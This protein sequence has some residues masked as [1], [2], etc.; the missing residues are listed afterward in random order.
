MRPTEIASQAIASA[1]HRNFF[2]TLTSEERVVEVLT[3]HVG[4]WSRK[5]VKDAK[6]GNRGSLRT[7]SIAIHNRID[8]PDDLYPEIFQICCVFADF[9][10]IKDLLSR[11]VTRRRSL[12]KLH[13][14]I[15]R[16]VTSL[17]IMGSEVIRFA[18][19]RNEDAF[20][21]LLREHWA[22]VVLTIMHVF[23]FCKSSKSKVAADMPEARLD[24]L[25]ILCDAMSSLFVNKSICDL[26]DQ[27]TARLLLEFAW[28][29]WL[30][31]GP[32][33]IKAGSQNAFNTSAAGCLTRVTEK[34]DKELAF[35]AASR[36]SRMYGGIP[37][38][39]NIALNAFH[40]G[41]SDGILH[42]QQQDI[43][44]FI[45]A[46]TQERRTNVF[47][48]A[49]CDSNGIPKL[50]GDL[51]LLAR[52]L[53]ANWIC[54]Y[55]SVP[56]SEIDA[57][58]IMLAIINIVWR[59]HRDVE[60]AVRNG[61]LEVILILNLKHANLY[62]VTMRVISEILQNLPQYFVHYSVVKSFSDA[63]QSIIDQPLIR[64]LEG[65]MLK[66][67]TQLAET[68]RYLKRMLTESC[69]M[70]RFFDLVIYPG[71]KTKYCNTC[72]KTL[73]DYS[74][75]ACSCTRVYYCSEQCRIT[76][77]KE[78]GHRKDCKQGV[79]RFDKDMA[80]LCFVANL[81]ISTRCTELLDDMI[82][83]LKIR[84]DDAVFQMLSISPQLHVSAIHTW[85]AEDWMRI[86]IGPY[87]R[88]DRVV[89]IHT[90]SYPR[91]P[92]SDKIRRDGK[93]GSEIEIGVATT[94]LSGALIVR[95]ISYDPDPRVKF[96][97]TA[98]VLESSYFSEKEKI[99]GS[100]VDFGGK[101]L[102][103]SKGH[104]VVDNIMSKFYIPGQDPW[105][106]HLRKDGDGREV[107]KRL[108]D[109][110]DDSITTINGMG[111]ENIES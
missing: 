22:Y 69:C 78:D 73:G 4:D 107:E 102:D 63:M 3:R 100:L 27:P 87:S 61:L 38:L 19:H 98:K 68:W 106:R 48:K 71:L 39:A 91:S 49:I 47:L 28:I 77:W 26:I 80:F 41:V 64:I 7:I 66:G 85:V 36:G 70:M 8:F 89:R 20:A 109:V 104:D 65:N 82:G 1:A 54:T 95:Y 67:T 90:R 103:G 42:A 33:E 9:G 76:N 32:R 92:E 55:P 58:P 23:K 15:E 52:R 94:G 105:T 6:A 17:W 24:A 51:N 16:V 86:N 57:N 40:C 88:N 18:I 14:A 43:P 83:G 53:Y 81:Y 56:I 10:R 111:Y 2:C 79:D 72:G 31:G 35:E 60:M 11:G 97:S 62:P 99:R 25:C 13:K 50:T 37:A 46:P 84:I 45:F 101:T 34:F 44:F 21:P 59:S 75:K 5:V 30:S 110:I 29:L 12:P 93:A 74:L 108:L 96:Q